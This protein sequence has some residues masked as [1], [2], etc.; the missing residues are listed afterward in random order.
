[1]EGGGSSKVV[2]ERKKEVAEGKWQDTTAQRQNTK[3]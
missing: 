1:M 2:R 3:F